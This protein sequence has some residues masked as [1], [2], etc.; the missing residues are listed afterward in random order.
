MGESITAYQGK[1]F[2][3]TLQ[4]HLGSTNYGW[5]LISMP[6]EVILVGQSNDPVNGFSLVNQVFYFIAVGESKK[7]SVEL[8]FGLCCLTQSSPFTYE[9]RVK[10]AVN[11]IPANDTNG[12]KF[13][14]YSENA[15]SYSPTHNLDLMAVLKYGYP[16][17]QN[18][19]AALKYGYPPVLK[20]G[21]P[22]GQDDCATVKYGYPPVLKYGY[23][24]GQDDCA[25][26]KY[27]YPPVL[28]YGYP[29]GQDD[30]AALK[31][32][33][34]PVLKYGYPCGQDDMTAVKYG[35]PPVLKYGYPCDQCDCE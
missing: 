13:V 6:A 20:Y 18:D 31:Y 10:V 27:G 21:Y 30:M 25:T 5:C 14:K 1:S 9:E 3:V 19:M 8:D 11:I 22:C 32:G 7:Q 24:C 23:P 4:S 12:R 2:S 16:C 28:K 34:P 15:A 35:Y 26:V 33:Y 29:C 17:G